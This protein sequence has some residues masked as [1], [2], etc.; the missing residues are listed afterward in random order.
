MSTNSA[1]VKFSTDNQ[2]QVVSTPAKGITFVLGQS[3]KG[4]FAK[5]SSIIN[6]WAQFQEEYGGLISSSVAPLLVKRM[7]DKG[8]PLRFSRVGH[9]TTITDKT[10]LDAVKAI[11]SDDIVMGLNI[12]FEFQPKN[13]GAWANGLNVFVTTGSNGDAN[14]FDISFTH[15]TDSNINEVYKNLYIPTNNPNVNQSNYLV[16]IVNNSKVFDVVYK[17]LSGFTGQLVPEPIQIN[18]TTGSDGTAPVSV[19]YSGDSAA[20]NGFHAFDNYTDAMQMIV[21]DNLD[22]ATHIAGAAYAKLRG[23][24]FYFLHIANTEDTKTK[25]IA[26]R[27]ALLINTKFCAIFGGGLSVT[28]PSNNQVIDIEAISDIVALASNSDTDFGEWYSFAGPNRG[29]IDNALSVVNDYGSPAKVQDLDNLA[30]RQINMIINRHNSIK[31]WGNFSA[32]L[33]NDSESQL[34]IAR[35]VVFLQ[36]SLKP[37]LE[38]Y[39]EEPN[40]IPTW[41]RIYYTIKPFLDGLVNKRALFSYDWQG[42]QDVSSLDSLVVNNA[43]DVRLGKYK[44]KFVIKP[45]ASI[46]EISI[47]ITLT[48]TSVDFKTV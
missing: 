15:D 21:A 14:Y 30:N 3:E 27:D 20:G 28:N 29:V 37:L 12:L 8:A 34:S 10:T 26:K 35:L 2:T 25:I 42:D 18:Y 39:L 44:V 45:I 41:K 6:T 23:D 33:K 16:D 1:Q 17:D 47:V 43:T 40:D 11:V 48:Q 31:L 19:D 7:L 4:P 24:L 46:Q 36:K 5:P 38:T 9:Y 32:Q 22:D 13:P